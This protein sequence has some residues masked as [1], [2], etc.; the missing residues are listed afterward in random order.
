MNA[1]T[2]PVDSTSVVAGGG[3]GTRISSPVSISSSPVTASALSSS[4]YSSVNRIT[5]APSPAEKIQ[6]LLTF[7][8]LELGLKARQLKYR[9]I[10]TPPPTNTTGNNTESQNTTESNPTITSSRT[11]LYT[12]EST[13]ESFVRRLAWTVDGAFLIT[14][15]A[16]WHDRTTTP[17]S[18]SSVSSTSSSS[19]NGAVQYATLMFARHKYDEPYRILTGLEKVSTLIYVYDWSALPNGDGC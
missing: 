17:L 2:S 15:A 13:L 11:W 8:K 6:E 3:S 4:T 1:L 5:Q 9:K 18:S 12:D 10:S 14:P 7:S 19:S 16:L